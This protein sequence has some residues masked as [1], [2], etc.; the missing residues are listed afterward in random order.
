M[1]MPLDAARGPIRVLELRSVFGTGGGPEKTILRGAAD[2]DAQQF[3][4]T[5]CYIRDRRDR[6]F[7]LKDLARALGVD[8]YV[9]VIER[10]SFDLRIWFQLRRLIKARQIDVVHSH[11]YKT[12]LL[13]LLLQT[14]GAVAMSTAHGWTG[15][16]TRE[17]RLY[18]PLDRWLLSRFPRVIAVSSEIRARLI[19]SGARPECVTTVLNGINPATFV[20][21]AGVGRR[22]REELGIPQTATLI[23]G[24]GRLESQK[25]F[26][27]LID[28]FARVR[29]TRGDVRLMILGDGS[30]ARELKAHAAS[31]GVADVCIFTGH[32]GDVVDALQAADFFVQSSDYEGTPNAVLEAMALEVPVVATAAGGT[33]ELVADGIEGLVVPVGDVQALAAAIGAALDDPQAS[34]VRAAAARRRVEQQ[35]SFERRRKTVEAL[36]EALVESRRSARRRRVPFS[37]ATCEKQ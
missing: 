8:D 24:L 16:T 15:Q 14:T 32:R 3:S 22:V 23:A 28:A 12:D 10:H 7:A 17:T 9:E 35:L 36:Y 26:D 25:R 2:S 29:Q 21:R 18:Y 33:N 27:L 1:T 37:E 13:A 20:R 31:S 34:S 5:V 30:L 11:D 6:V 19:E 4:I